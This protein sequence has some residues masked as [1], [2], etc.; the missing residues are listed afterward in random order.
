MIFES[1]R[2]LVS[3]WLGSG[4]LPDFLSDLISYFGC[5]FIFCIPF[6]LVVFGL[7]LIYRGL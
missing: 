7:R 6:L 1:L 4:P 2:T 5:F 3:S